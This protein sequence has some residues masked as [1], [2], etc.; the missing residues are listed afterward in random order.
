MMHKPY[1]TTVATI[2]VVILISAILLWSVFDASEDTG[3][4]VTGNVLDCVVSAHSRQCVVVI[5]P[6]NE[7]VWVF[8]PA[9]KKGD[10]I[11]LK[12][13]KRPITKAV[14]YAVSL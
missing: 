7:Q 4:R 3:V 1:K 14:S 12:Q 10:A 11:V 5:A 9:G 8:I 6:S 2:I 13:M